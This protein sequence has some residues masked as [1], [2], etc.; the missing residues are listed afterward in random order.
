MYHVL[1]CH[2][3]Q[4]GDDW[5][6]RFNSGVGAQHRPLRSCVSGVNLEVL[7]SFTHPV[8]PEP[9]CTSLSSS[10]EQSMLHRMYSRLPLDAAPAPLTGPP[11]ECGPGSHRARA[12]ACRYIDHSSNDLLILS[13]RAAHL[14]L[15]QLTGSF[16]V[17]DLVLIESR[18]DSGATRC[19]TSIKGIVR[20]RSPRALGRNCNLSRIR[21]LKW[22]RHHSSVA[23]Y[24]DVD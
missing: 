14:L 17:V 22:F 20:L 2:G 8:C 9:P 4:S 5:E 21:I 12:S 3:Q 6:P 24:W 13:L 16:P 23:F 10:A 7:F 1:T 15:F 19:L 18:V 11:G